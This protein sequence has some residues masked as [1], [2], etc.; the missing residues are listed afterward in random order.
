MYN[1][2]VKNMR[3]HKHLELVL[4]K[5]GKW[6]EHVEEMTTR[7]MRRVDILRGLMWRLNGQTIEKLY[8]TYITPILE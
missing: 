7:A 4:E 5:E 6:K 1:T 2:S 8:T 3:Q